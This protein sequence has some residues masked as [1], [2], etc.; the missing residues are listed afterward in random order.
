MTYTRSPL[1][2]RTKVQVVEVNLHIYREAHLPRHSYLAVGGGAG[3]ST[4]LGM[5][6]AF[7]E[8]AEHARP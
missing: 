7:G 4:T 5:V 3:R 8:S 1:S 6:I 2:D